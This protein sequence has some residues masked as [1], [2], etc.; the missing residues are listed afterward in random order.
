MA[1]D[2]SKLDLLLKMVEENEKKRVVADERTRAEYLELKKMVESRIP[3]VERKVE[4]IGEAFQAMNTKVDLIESTLQRQ[5]KTEKTSGGN[6]KIGTASGPS[7]PKFSGTPDSNL[8]PHAHYSL[9]LG[10]KQL[11]VD[12]GAVG[13]SGAVP[14]MLCPQFSG[15][16]PQMWRANCEQYFDLYGILPAN[17]VKIATLNFVGNAAFWLQ[18]VRTQLG[19]I[20]WPDLCEIV[21]NR[22]ARDRKRELI[23]QWIHLNQTG[24]VS[25]Y[26]EKFDNLMHQLMAYGNSDIPDY[27]VTKFIE[28]LRDDIRTV[29]MVQ[30]PPDLDAACS[31][32]LLLEEALEGCKSLSYKK[33]DLIVGTRPQRP[34]SS[35]NN[36]TLSITNSEDRRGTDAARARDDKLAALK[37]Y[38]R[39]KG[40][41]FTCGER[42]GKEHKCATTIQLHVVEELLEA[43]SVEA[44]FETDD[45]N[46]T[47]ETLMAISQQA[48]WGIESSKSI[49]LR[50]WIQGFELLML[51]DSGSTHSF[52]DASIGQKLSGLKQLDNPVA[53]KIAD[54]GTMQCTQEIPN[55]NW[56][57]QGYNFSSNFRLLYLGGYDIIL[58]M[59]WLESYSPMHIDWVH[60]WLE[61]PY[62][63]TTVRLQGLLP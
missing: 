5:I 30:K 10:H 18:S 19:G 54:G 27:F 25:E 15:D 61:F 32:A 23:R 24:T 39:S 36:R 20:S 29:V 40:L 44:V 34:I 49:K 13:F 31:V 50:G 8:F 35:S 11:D 53:V 33:S 48:M 45:E 12:L 41:C 58:G 22:F 14:P 38:R 4:D 62:Q 60:K 46:D 55:C 2:S 52:V 6:G 59:D 56:W 47:K 43:V 7:S 37:A 51:I 42:W 16:S 28:G 9:D 21:C 17:W 63:G 57:M 26:V 3:A 1:Q